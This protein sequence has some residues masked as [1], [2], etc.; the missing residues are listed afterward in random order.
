MNKRLLFLVVSAFSLIACKGGGSDE[1]ES[2]KSVSQLLYEEYD[3]MQ[4]ELQNG[5]GYLY[6]YKLFLYEYEGNGYC[7]IV[8]KRHYLTS[9]Y[10]PS[11]YIDEINSNLGSFM[12]HYATKERVVISALCKQP[13][14]VN[15]GLFIVDA[16]GRDVSQ[17]EAE[18]IKQELIEGV[19]NMRIIE[20]KMYFKKHYDELS[21]E[22][23]DAINTLV[24]M[25]VYVI[26]PGQSLPKK[27]REK[28]ETDEEMLE[29]DGIE[30]EEELPPPTPD[31]V[32]GEYWDKSKIEIIE[33]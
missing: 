33:L 17:K 20:A 3:Q 5:E 8:D 13:V 16:S 2:E 22:Q 10:L 18:K 26:E 11:I 30:L 28:F 25:N 15:K 24:P 21:P 9:N 14:E 32:D 19:H 29:M 1:S 12:N 31:G 7:C 23:R 4:D 6:D 27:I